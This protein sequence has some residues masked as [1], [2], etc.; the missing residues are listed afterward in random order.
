MP[1]PRIYHTKAQRSAANR[2]KSA[3]H[4]SKNKA[5]I[6]ARRHAGTQVQ[7][8]EDATKD[9]HISNPQAEAHVLHNIR[10]AQHT[11]QKLNILINNSPSTFAKTLYIKYMKTHEAGEDDTSILQGPLD[12]V[13]RWEECLSKCRGVVLQECGVGTESRAVDAAHKTASVVIDYLQDILHRA[14]SNVK[15]LQATY[16]RGRLEFQLEV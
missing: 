9:T 12:R 1:R 6:L 16:K 2:A 15:A 7:S 13:L 11:R 5:Q 4:Y 8:G 3:R 14:K 10:L